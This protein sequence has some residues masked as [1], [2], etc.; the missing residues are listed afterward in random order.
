MFVSTDNEATY[1]RLAGETVLGSPIS[2]VLT[3]AAVVSNY[4]VLTILQTLPLLH[5]L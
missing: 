3:P 4:N 1:S 5:Y 2:A